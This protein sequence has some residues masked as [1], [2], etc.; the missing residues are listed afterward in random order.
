MG[1]TMD[2]LITGGTGNLARHCLTELCEHGHRVTLFDRYRPEEAAR[3]WSTDVPVVVGDLTS[4]EDCRRAVETAKAEAI[5]H[6][7]AVAYPSKSGSARRS[8]AAAGQ[9]AVATDA[10][11]RV[12]TLG[13]YF[14]LDA[15]RQAGT[16]GG[17]CFHS[18]G[19]AG[20]QGD[21]ELAHDAAD[22]R[23]PGAPSD[24]QL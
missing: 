7:G 18:L 1:A 24:E 14:L 5:V 23:A 4:A 20:D 21:P 13:T 19:A 12:N 6:L 17:V 22:R 3:P 15:A 9:H 8:A 10:T 2:V 16:R 11:F